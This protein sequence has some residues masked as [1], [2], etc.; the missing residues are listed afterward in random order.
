MVNELVGPQF[1]LADFKD[2]EVKEGDL[3]WWVGERRGQKAFVDTPRI[4][5]NKCAP[6][7]VDSGW[8][9]LRQMWY[10]AVDQEEWESM[11]T[12]CGRRRRKSASRRLESARAAVET[13]RKMRAVVVCFDEK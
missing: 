13:E 1:N 6:L 4:D 12:R 8:S 5:R 11:S 3:S 2:T 7:L 9:A 10:D